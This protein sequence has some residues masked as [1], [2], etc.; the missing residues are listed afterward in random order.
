MEVWLPVTTKA[1]LVRQVLVQREKSFIQVL[2]DL[3]EWWTPVWKTIS[4]FCHGKHYQCPQEGQD[5]SRCPEFL[6]HFKVQFFGAFRQLLS[7]LTPRP[8]I[9]TCSLLLFISGSLMEPVCG[10]H[11][12]MG[13]TAARAIWSHA[14]GEESTWTHR[15][16]H[17]QV[18]RRASVTMSFY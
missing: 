11:T 12:T 18:S 13:H 4:P 9:L 1:K 5:K 10:S 8:G 17:H 14:P 6:L 2:H 15:Q 16:V 7:S 3:G